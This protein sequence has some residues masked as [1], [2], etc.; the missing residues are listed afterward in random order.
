MRRS[1]A[2]LFSAAICTAASAQ[3]VHDGSLGKAG[4]VGGQPALILPNDGDARGR[5]VGQNVFYSFSRFDLAK[6]QTARFLNPGQNL[7]I[8]NILARV[9]SGARSSIDGTIEVVDPQTN[10]F[11]MN[12]AGF[13][14]GPSARLDVQGSVLFTSADYIKLRDGAQFDANVTVSPVLTSAPPSAFGFLGVQ[15]PG[16]IRIN[17]ATVDQTT[18]SVPD[19]AVMSMIG[20]DVEIG[21]T[22]LVATGGRINLISVAGA[23][24]VA[25]DAADPNVRALP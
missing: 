11:M 10:L 17:G 1:I 23:G 6:G 4:P 18:L 3:I 19:G 21:A 7:P 12:P 13:I 14:F 2:F 5:V 25:F 15:R 22:R 16:A 8:R 24:E 9:T 20:G